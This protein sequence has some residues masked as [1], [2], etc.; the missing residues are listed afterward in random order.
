MQFLHADAS[1][2][3]KIGATVFLVPCGI[4]GFIMIYDSLF[5]ALAGHS[6]ILRDRMNCGDGFVNLFASSPSSPWQ[7]GTRQQGWHNSGTLR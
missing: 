2:L 4:I 1:V 6:C 7:H 5:V 3:G